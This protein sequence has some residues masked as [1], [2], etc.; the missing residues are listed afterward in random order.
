[1]TERLHIHIS[2]SCIGE[3]N[4]NPHQYSCLEKPRDGG[5]WW[6]AVYGV[7]QSQTRL[8][9]LSSS[10]SSIRVKWWKK[11][12]WKM[13]CITQ[14]LGLL[15]HTT[16]REPLAVFLLLGLWMINYGAE[17]SASYRQKHSQKTTEL[18]YPLLLHSL[19]LTFPP[20]WC[21]FSLASFPVQSCL[22]HIKKNLIR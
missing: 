16:G 13:I 19:A 9:R 21:N 15:F 6:A 14:A 22:I 11:Q 2:L 4:G 12:S 17:A 10:S 5:A 3:G 18:A 8:K 7:A 20:Y 1:M